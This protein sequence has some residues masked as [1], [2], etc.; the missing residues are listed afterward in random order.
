M[1]WCIDELVI[2]LAPRAASSS[3]SLTAPRRPTSSIAAHGDHGLSKARGARS[4]AIAFRIA[5]RKHGDDT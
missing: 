2:S 5:N 1:K 4:A 3:T